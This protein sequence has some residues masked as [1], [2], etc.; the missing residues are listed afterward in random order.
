MPNPARGY[1]SYHDRVFIAG[2]TGSGK[3]YLAKYIS[4]RIPRL[5]VLDSKG[6]LADWNL[7]PWDWQ[8]KLKLRRGEPVRAR[9]V[10]DV[11]K[12]SETWIEAMEAA[13]EAGNCTVYIDEVYSIVE[14]GSKPPSIMWGLWTRGRELKVGAWAST[15]RPVS[16]PLF[17]ISEAEHYF[18]FRLTLDEDRKRMA[19]YMGPQVIQPVTDIHGFWYSQ[20]IDE[21]AIYTTQLEVASNGKIERR[22]EAISSPV[23]S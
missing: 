7:E 3:T 13:Y 21:R 23:V 18:C 1:I 11:Q 22:A 12:E 4:R 16:V 20:A 8:A 6:T 15:Q 17:T 10:Y 5:I 14:P 9:V 2:K 19:G